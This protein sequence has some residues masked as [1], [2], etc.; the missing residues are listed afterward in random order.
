MVHSSMQE[1]VENS[2][3][4]GPST[5]RSVSPQVLETVKME[6]SDDEVVILS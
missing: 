4:S 1:K 5:S 6:H 3:W 2:D